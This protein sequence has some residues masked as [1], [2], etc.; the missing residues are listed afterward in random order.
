MI[1]YFGLILI[2]HIVISSNFK[3]ITLNTKIRLHSSLYY[4]KR[5]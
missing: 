1:E 3:D 5:N 2:I 4:F